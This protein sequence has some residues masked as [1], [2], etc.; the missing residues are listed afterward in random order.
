MADKTDGKMPAHAGEF[1]LDEVV[2]LKGHHFKIV[3][4]DGYTGKIAM[5]WIT[6]EEAE[7]L[8]R[9]G[10]A[11]RTTSAGTT[12]AGAVSEKAAASSRGR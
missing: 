8:E 1:N 3:L 10:A 9:S 12:G 5:K 4:V 11:A 6:P 2:R 7:V